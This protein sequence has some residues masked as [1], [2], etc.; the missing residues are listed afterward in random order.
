MLQQWMPHLTIGFGDISKDNLSQIV[1]FLAGRDFNWEITVNN[2]AFIYDTGTKQ[3]LK[4]CFD[5][6]REAIPG[7]SSMERLY[8]RP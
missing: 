7:E 1:P 3:E 8:R 4:A 2:L 5:I 6:T